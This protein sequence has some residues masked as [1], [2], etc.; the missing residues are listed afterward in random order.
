MVEAAVHGA[1]RSSASAPGQALGREPSAAIDRVDEGDEGPGI[2]RFLCIGN[3][4]IVSGDTL[5]DEVGASA[6]NG[7]AV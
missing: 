5:A 2:H 4:T 6:Q 3:G 1:F 7:G